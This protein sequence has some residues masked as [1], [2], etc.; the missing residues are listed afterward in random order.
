MQTISS[1]VERPIPTSSIPQHTEAV[2]LRGMVHA[3]RNL[4]SVCFVVLRRADGIVQCVLQEGLES[5]REG[6]AVELR[7]KAVPE[8]RAPGGFEL[9]VEALRILS[10]AYAPMPVPIHKAKMNLSM[11]TE[12]SLRP[13]TLR[14]LRIRAGMK[15]QEGLV[16][17]FREALSDQGFTEVHTPKLGAQSAE[18]GANVF[19]LT[20]FGQRAC[21]AQSPQLYKQ[22]MAGVYERVFEVGPVFRAEKHNTVRHL[23]EY[24]SLDLE[25]AFIDGFE[26]IM[27]MET[28]VLRRMMSVLAADYAPQLE[29]LDVDLPAVEAIPA[30]RFDEAKA[31]VAQTYGYVVRDPYDLA[32]EEEQLIGRYAKEQWG[33]DFVFVTHYPSAK[34]PFYA[35]D[36][37]DDPRYT[38][39]F[40]LLFRG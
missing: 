14:N 2:T 1:A 15:L 16:R 3:L 25:M 10:S 21:L 6:D 24:T 8:E 34:R 30:I 33:S 38:L 37:P 35:M 29:A 11:E 19:K 36:D 9:R 23:S 27:A 17:G 13:I 28:Y 20:Y 22:M 7:G 40:D 18:G 12:L 5:P 26:D 4:G 32:P 39:S 31:C